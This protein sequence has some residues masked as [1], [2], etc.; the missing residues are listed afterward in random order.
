MNEKFISPLYDFVFAEIFGSE[1]NIENTKAFLKA[2]L[3]IPEDD[4]DQLTIK[5]PTL[6]R[7]FRR[8]K[9]GIVDLKLTTKSGKIIHIELQVEN[10][11]N[12]RNRIL[13][14][15][16]RLIGDQL[17]MGEDYEKLHHVISIVIC[18][19]ILL[20]EESS[21]INM[22]ELR[23]DKNRSFTDLM[24]VVILE[25]PKLPETE[26][27]SV[28]PWLRFF[29]CRKKEEFEMLARAYPMLRDVVH[30]IKNIG[31]LG[32]WRDY[33]FHKNLQK[34]DER[35][36]IEQIKIDAR[37]EGKAEGKAKGKAE[38]R[39]YFMELLDQ[40]LTVEEIKQR[41]TN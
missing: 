30:T 8:G 16:A 23:N 25:L 39:Q 28:W 35:M 5:N 7:L 14:Y 34:T 26:D 11:S 40:G 37:D 32:M 41:L 1:E 21:Y 22:Y 24:R 17:I 31:V 33:R 15:G 12:M 2:L 29:K 36:R 4:Y 3:D 19:H 18:D 13:Y 6:K 10:K 20:E 27:H 38:E 9:K